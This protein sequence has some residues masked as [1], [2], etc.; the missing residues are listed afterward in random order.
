MFLLFLLL[1]YV[2]MT[3]PLPHTHSSKQLLWNNVSDLA[4]CQLVP[5]KLFPLQYPSKEC[6]RPL[7]HS[8]RPRP[9]FHVFL[10][11]SSFS[12]P[13]YN[14]NPDAYRETCSKYF[15]NVSVTVTKSSAKA[16]CAIDLVS[17]ILFITGPPLSF[18]SQSKAI[19]ANPSIFRHRSLRS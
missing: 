10:L 4:Q 18:T 6:V 11:V 5:H 8:S 16:A 19:L 13:R 7:P 9:S 12:H 17:Q 1:T 2:T 14:V 15:P 3:S